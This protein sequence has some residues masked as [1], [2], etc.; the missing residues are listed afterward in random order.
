MRKAKHTDN[1]YTLSESYRYLANAKETISKSPIGYGIYTDSKYVREAAG[2]AYLAALKA[3]DVFFIS[4]GMKKAELPQSIEEY[5]TFIKKKI[6]L[7]GKLNSALTIVYQNL[8]IFAYYRGGIGMEMV[9][10]GFDNARKVI[11]M[12]SKLMDK[13]KETKNLVCEPET[14]YQKLKRKKIKLIK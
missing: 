13:P 7:N 12:I 11:E 1:E 9:K 3:L 10:E 14:K 6:L 8:H 4:K 2:I 5:Q